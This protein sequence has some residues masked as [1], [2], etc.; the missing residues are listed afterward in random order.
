MSFQGWDMNEDGNI[1]VFPV[2]G[3]GTATFMKGMAGGL[4]LEFLTD[5]SMMKTSSLQVV[6]TAPQVRELS[7]ALAT[8]AV[9]LESELRDDKPTSAAN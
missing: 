9:R 5:R 8:L 1:Q 6:L 3:W 2:I 4:R 7:D